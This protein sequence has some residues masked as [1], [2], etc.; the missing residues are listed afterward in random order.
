MAVVFVGML[1]SNAPKVSDTVK[2]ATTSLVEVQ[3]NTSQHTADA[4]EV[5]EWAA[6]GR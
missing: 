2:G 4:N 5:I 3:K 6:N 1:W